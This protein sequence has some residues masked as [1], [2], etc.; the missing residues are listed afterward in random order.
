MLHLVSVNGKGYFSDNIEFRVFVQERF[1]VLFKGGWGHAS[2]SSDNQELKNKQVLCQHNVALT[3]QTWMLPQMS[4]YGQVS[5][6][7]AERDHDGAGREESRARHL[8]CSP[9]CP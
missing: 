9:F 5:G 6:F 4:G 3:S 1:L 8:D 7:G 2:L